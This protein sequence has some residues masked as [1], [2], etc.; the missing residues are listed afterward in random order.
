MIP[1][2]ITQSSEPTQCIMDSFNLI[3]YEHNHTVVNDMFSWITYDMSTH[4]HG[5]CNYDNF[6][7]PILT[8]YLTEYL[9]LQPQ[10]SLYNMPMIYY[11]K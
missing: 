9:Q 5:S 2:G 4:A 1:C 6:S 7:L 3:Y 11:V 8:A 10:F